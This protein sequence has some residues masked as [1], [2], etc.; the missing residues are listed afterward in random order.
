MWPVFIVKFAIE[1]DVYEIGIIVF[2]HY[3]I[4]QVCGLEHGKILLLNF[5]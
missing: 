5:Q 1:L 4:S 3:I 2:F